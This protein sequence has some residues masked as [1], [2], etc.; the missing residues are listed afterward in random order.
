MRAIVYYISCVQNTLLERKILKQCVGKGGRRLALRWRKK[1][2]KEL[3][4]NLDRL[5]GSDIRLYAL[6]VGLPN[7][8]A[9]VVRVHRVYGVGEAYT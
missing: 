9:C 3:T 8:A 6:I 4:K 7:T 1:R 5:C 2:R